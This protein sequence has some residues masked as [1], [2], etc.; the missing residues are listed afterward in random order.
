MKH[1]QPEHYSLVD[2]VEREKGMKACWQY[3]FAWRCLQNTLLAFC[4]DQLKRKILPLGQQKRL[5]SVT[6]RS[7][8]LWLQ[9]LHHNLSYSPSLG[10]VLPTFS[11]TVTIYRMGE[12]ADCVGCYMHV[13]V[14]FECMWRIWGLFWI[15]TALFY[16]LWTWPW[17]K[18][19]P[20]NS[21]QNSEMFLISNGI[22][23]KKKARRYSDPI[24]FFTFL[25]PEIQNKD[26]YPKSQSSDCSESGCV[27]NCS[28]IFFYCIVF[29]L[30]V[31]EM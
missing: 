8:S 30:A 20:N 5:L 15:Q 11:F 3:T 25:V 23:K 26:I 18:L 4:F 31:C 9:A 13:G 6:Q 17:R 28:K 10:D 24:L 22:R 29:N 12:T 27:Y 14:C 19:F 16:V 21:R 2:G 1:K 7:F